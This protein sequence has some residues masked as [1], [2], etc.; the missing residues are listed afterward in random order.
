V[1][2]WIFP[3]N[4]FMP[5]IIGISVIIPAHNEGRNLALLLPELKGVLDELG[6]AFEILI[7]CRTVDPETAQVAAAFGARTLEQEERGYGGA[8]IAGFDAAQGEYFL[9]I[10]ADLSHKPVFIRDFWAQREGADVLIASRY[11]HGGHAIM[12]LGRYILSR[13]LNFFF[14]PRPQPGC[15]RYV[16]RFSVV[17]GC[18]DLGSGVG[19]ARFRRLAGVVGP[20][21]CGRLARTRDSL[22]LRSP[23][24]RQFKRQNFPLRISLSED[25]PSTLDIAP[26]P[27]TKTAPSNGLIFLATAFALPA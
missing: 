11:V 16:K 12:P 10:D 15:L 2:E 26:L 7:V 22:H 17:P 1:Q 3:A 8:L 21:V 13:T 5:N 19:R 20:S 14:Q 24:A 23:P 27:D 18:R 4:D 25:I 9:T 6:T